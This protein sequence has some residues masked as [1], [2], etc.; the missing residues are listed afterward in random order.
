MLQINDIIE[1]NSNNSNNY[2]IND[3]IINDNVAKVN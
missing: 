3:E 2:S 1:N